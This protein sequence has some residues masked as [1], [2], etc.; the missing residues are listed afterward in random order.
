QGAR[1]RTNWPEDPVRQKSCRIDSTSAE[2]TVSEKHCASF[3]TH[4]RLSN[5]L[6]IS[7]G[8]HCIRPLLQSSSRLSARVSSNEATENTAART[9]GDRLSLEEPPCRSLIQIM[10][11]AFR[12]DRSV[13]RTQKRAGLARHPPVAEK[14]K[15]QLPSGTKEYRVPGLLRTP[16]RDKNRQC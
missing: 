2:G 10:L 9:D 13:T 8:P 1:N 5:S 12:R 16:P 14:P 4:K 7:T 3:Q 15:K 6:Y 11:A